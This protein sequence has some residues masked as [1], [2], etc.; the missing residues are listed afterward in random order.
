MLNRQLTFKEFRITG[1][2]KVIANGSYIKATPNSG[3]VVT[4]ILVSVVAEV[5]F[6]GGT[7]VKSWSN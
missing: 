2:I 5:K 3:R 6:K 4:H 7:S 1:E